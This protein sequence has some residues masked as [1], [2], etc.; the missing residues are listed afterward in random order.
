MD[1]MTKN[2]LHLKMSQRFQK[3][4]K[5]MLPLMSQYLTRACLASSVGLCSS[6]QLVCFS[7]AQI[8]WLQEAFQKS[9]VVSSEA[10]TKE[11]TLQKRYLR[12][13]AFCDTE[14]CGMLGF[15]LK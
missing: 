12:N 5:T 11:P 1:I 14:E 7:S 3:A 9:L 10:A 15:Y 6:T 2:S 8:H 4:M 13:W